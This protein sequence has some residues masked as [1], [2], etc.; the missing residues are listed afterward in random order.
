LERDISGADKLVVSDGK[1]QLEVD[2]LNKDLG[3]KFGA[4]FESSMAHVQ[5]ELKRHDIPVLPVNTVAPVTDQLRDKLGGRR[6]LP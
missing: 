4:S 6:V 1:Y 2:P 5:E 3:V